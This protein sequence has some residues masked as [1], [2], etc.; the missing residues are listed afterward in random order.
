[1]KNPIEVRDDDDEFFGIF[2]LI[3]SDGGYF[4]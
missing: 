3:G 2:D 4:C 1:V